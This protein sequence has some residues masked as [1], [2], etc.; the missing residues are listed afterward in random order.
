MVQCPFQRASHCKNIK[1]KKGSIERK[2][3]IAEL[4]NKG[5]FDRN[6][7]VIRTGDGEIV[8]KRRTRTNNPVDMFHV[9]IAISCFLIHILQDSRTCLFRD[10]R[11]LMSRSNP[12]TVGRLMLPIGPIISSKFQD[13]ILSRMKDDNILLAIRSDSVIL[14]FGQTEFSLL[15]HDIRY[16]RTITDRIRELGRLVIAL[17]ELNL[18]VS[19]LHQIFQPNRYQLFADGVRKVAGS[20]PVTNTFKS[21]SLVLKIG[22][23]IR[24]CIAMLKGDYLQD[25]ILQMKVPELD[26]FLEV[27]N[28]KW[29]NDN[30]ARL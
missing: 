15:Q 18:S 20:D 9:S 8:P 7:E 14:H 24:K 26:S 16:R 30:K 17:K 25:D 11:T 13:E 29:T 2:T 6:K 22:F 3:R 10:Q 1:L 27:L 5:T 12:R 28:C 19:K 4:R 21:S 23:S